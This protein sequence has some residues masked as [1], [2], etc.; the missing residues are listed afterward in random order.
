MEDCSREDGRRLSNLFNALAG[1]FRER[2]LQHRSEPRVVQFSISDLSPESEGRLMPLLNIARRALLLYV[3][4]GP[5]KAGG[6]RE[7]F[8]VPNR[9]LW[10][11]RGLDPLGQ[12]GRASLKASDL[13]AAATS[14]RKIPF[15][16]AE[17]SGAGGQGKL[18]DD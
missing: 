6:R 14:G 1:Y 17:L 18:F 5:A 8:Y 11:A 16:P 15:E 9:M 7:R 10:P 3:R 13:L 12:H 2:L 4:L